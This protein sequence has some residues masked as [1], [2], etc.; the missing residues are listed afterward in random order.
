M[1]QLGDKIYNK[2]LHLAFSLD[3][4][5]LKLGGEKIILIQIT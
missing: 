4:V 1:R 2:L 5:T 3:N